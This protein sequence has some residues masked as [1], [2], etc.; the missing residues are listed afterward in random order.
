[1]PV[2]FCPRKQKTLHFN[3][4]P[5]LSERR[6][7]SDTLFARKGRLRKVSLNGE[8]FGY[9]QDTGVRLL[10]KSLSHNPE[11]SEKFSLRKTISEPSKPAILKNA[12]VRSQW[13]TGDE[14][15]VC[16]KRT[17]PSR[18]KITE[19]LD[20]QLPCS[21]SILPRPPGGNSLPKSILKDMNSST[22]STGSISVD[23]FYNF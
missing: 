18:H 16:M 23:F 17:A 9:I 11:L 13:E 2:S 12:F 8:C 5:F 7:F 1:M 4:S 3:T 21:E 20:I 15:M 22:I 6:S 10:S 19:T 14:M